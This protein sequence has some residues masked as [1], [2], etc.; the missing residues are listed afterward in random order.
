MRNR[1]HLPQ[2]FALLPTFRRRGVVRELIL[3]VLVGLT[4]IPCRIL[5]CNCESITVTVTIENKQATGHFDPGA[6][7]LVEDSSSTSES[8]SSASYS[9]SRGTSYTLKLNATAGEPP[10]G[11]SSTAT[12]SSC[13]NVLLFRK[14]QSE[15]YWQIG[16][17][18]LFAWDTPERTAGDCGFAFETEARSRT[19]YSSYFVK[20]EDTTG[21]LENDPVEETDLN[22]NGTIE[23]NEKSFDE[24][25]SVLFSSMGSQ[26]EA[27]MSTGDVS[28]GGGVTT[29]RFMATKLQEVKGTDEAG[30]WLEDDQKIV[31]MKTFAGW[32]T[33]DFYG[34]DLVKLLVGGEVVLSREISHGTV[35]QPFTEEELAPYLGTVLSAVNHSDEMLLMA[36]VSDTDDS[37][38]SGNGTSSGSSDDSGGGGFSQNG[39][40][41]EVPFNLDLGMGRN[42]QGYA[43]GT[44]KFSTSLDDPNVLSQSNV[45]LVQPF[46]TVFTEVQNPAVGVALRI[47]DSSTGVRVDEERATDGTALTFKVYTGDDNLVGTHVLTVIPEEAGVN[48]PGLRYTRTY[49]GVTQ[50]WEYYGKSTTGGRTWKEVSPDGSIKEGTDA[51]ISDSIRVSQRIE[52]LPGSTPGS[53]VVVRDD[54]TTYQTF[55]WGEEVVSRSQNLGGGLALATQYAYGTETGTPSYGKLVSQIN[56]DGSW[57]KSEYTASGTLLRVL[58]PW[59]DGPASPAAATLA[60]CRATTYTNMG[61][62][63]ES[64]E[65]E[66][67]QGKVTSRRYQLD[68]RAVQ[69]PLTLATEYAWQMGE[70]KA[71]LSA[72]VPD[73]VGDQATGAQNYRIQMVGAG[74]LLSEGGNLISQSLSSLNATD[75]V[76]ASG[77]NDWRLRS[78]SAPTA[79]SIQQQIELPAQPAQATVFCGSVD[80][81]TTNSQSIYLSV[82]GHEAF[83]SVSALDGAL[84]GQEVADQLSQSLSSQLNPDGNPPVAVVQIVNEGTGVLIQTPGTGAGQSINVSIGE[85][86]PVFTCDHDGETVHGSDISHPWNVVATGNWTK[87]GGGSTPA[88]AIANLISSDAGSVYDVTMT[89]RYTADYNL[90][91]SSMNLRK[92]APGV[93]RDKPVH[94][95]VSSS[96]AATAYSYEA[97]SFD[98]ITGSFNWNGGGNAVKTTTKRYAV[99]PDTFVLTGADPLSQVSME[100]Y[101]GLTRT[102]Q[103]WKGTDKVTETSH[104]YNPSTRD[105][106]F[107][108]ENGVTVFSA[109]RDTTN[110]TLTQTGADG[111]AVRTTYTS[112]GALLNTR[113][114]GRA[115]APDVISASSENGLESSSTTTAGGLTRKA[116]SVRDIAGRTVSSTDEN[117]L[118]T[119]YAYELGG[120]RV[121]ET[122]PNGGTRI[123]ENYLDGQL[124]SVTGTAVVPEYHT[125]LVDDDGNL[126][127]TVY[128]NDDGTGATRSPRWRSSTTNGLGWL[129]R[130]EAPAPGGAGVL[131]TVHHYNTKG[132]RVRTERPGQK[133]YLVT[134][135]DFGRVASQGVDIN[136]NGVLDLALSEPVTTTETTYESIDGHWWEKTTTVETASEDRSAPVRATISLRL[137]GGAL[138]EATVTATSDGLW[139]TTSTVRNPATKTV[140]TTTTTNRSALAAVQKV[141]NGLV[142]SDSSLT[143]TGSTT[144]EYDPLERI[145]TVTDPAGIT[146]RS[147]YDDLT[148][149][150]ARSRL[151]LEEVR[152]VGGTSFTT[153]R[154]YSYYPAGS[155][156]AGNVMT[157]TYANSTNTS[158]EYDLQGHQV[159]VSGSSSYPVR[160]QYD[161]Y[162]DLW[163]MHTYRT[164][165]PTSSSTGDVTTWHRDDATGALTSKEDASHRSASYT[166]EPATGRLH[167][168]TWARSPG[169]VSLT[170]TYIY[171]DAGRLWKVDYSD[172][173]PDVTYTY[174]ADGQLKTTG[175]AAGLHTY[176]YGGPNGTLSGETITGGLLDGASWASTFDMQKRRDSFTWAWGT[177]SRTT[178]YGYDSAGRLETVTAFGKTATYA[179][180]AGTGRLDTLSYTG[181]VGDWEYDEAGRLDKVVWSAGANVVSKH[182]YGYDAMHRR[183]TAIREN[184]EAWGYAY[185]DRGEVTGGAKKTSSAANAP[186]KQGLQFGYSYDLIGNRVASAEHTPGATAPD[187]LET[188]TGT[189]NE[190]NQITSRQHPASRWVLGHVH[191]A[192]TLNV[193]GGGTATREGDEFQ[194]P[195]NTTTAGAAE[196][197]GLE[198]TASRT[199]VGV[200]GGTVTTTRSGKLWFAASPESLQYD[201]D[202]N[203]T[204]DG[205]WSY[206][207]DAENRLKAMETLPS[208]ISAGVPPQ[209]LEFAYDAQGRRVRK[210]V[211]SF[212]S[213]TQTMEVTSDMRFLY[214]SWNLMAEF[215][216]NLQSQMPNLGFAFAWGRDL[217]G[218][219]QGAGGV[220]GL[221]LTELS[222][223]TTVN[224]P[225]GSLLRWQRQHHRLRQSRQQRGHLEARL[226][227]LRPPGVD[228]TRQWEW[229]EEQMPFRFQ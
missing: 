192:A 127:H 124:K 53:L 206:Q 21:V 118:T 157:V 170:T 89:E 84:S 147:V 22:D 73:L 200:G 63:A 13:S 74:M 201:F 191:P 113:K 129:I 139:T 160:Y 173:T 172:D 146:R 122:L 80:V 117:G 205:R 125:Y 12:V 56:P 197:R 166:Y 177:Q 19:Q 131:A 224:E 103:T 107:S 85:E 214:D 60:G 1:V 20:P 221:V 5:A 6:M 142:V 67:V 130:E 216:M 2:S 28:V 195:V 65:F 175:D 14:H 134:Y 96:G 46:S 77:T 62:G 98:S 33:V 102:E 83:F 198:V 61:S 25:K 24:R 178:S 42:S 186:V 219:M 121:I 64:W 225:P 52:R 148:D 181:L 208:A 190:L 10:C 168:R 43:D 133:D 132:Q 229:H 207:W 204:S 110:N 193:T 8:G 66:S 45:K 222:S 209:R 78:K 226:R 93:Q 151:K 30:P 141:V 105:R 4:A 111:T 112:A 88:P 59:L 38:D 26:P 162:G 92:N 215:A 3:A 50:V 163:K 101:Q 228:R 149:G 76:Y 87:I 179:Y 34:T 49:N 184:G 183:K 29:F 128:L 161:G 104:S 182:D 54:S 144:Y 210:V 176:I 138:N 143:A 187:G 44:V 218:T 154:S 194:I 16:S 212:N 223:S 70:W 164:G 48:D 137:I 199:G 95:T 165:T 17:T 37:N 40:D 9:I 152:P 150:T 156:G 136:G 220:G 180:E 71:S 23:A 116:T 145:A 86:S 169:G 55:P 91:D 94:F 68:W 36:W 185:N 79:F 159:F 32:G 7:S 57:T 213:T 188:V 51:K 97:G 115:G 140:T 41:S 109:L 31:G 171:D 27:W 196:W 123:T 158:Y 47:I 120:R 90:W 174:Y 82:N 189:P 75:V 108:K 211:K 155:A 69:N 202:G 167:T 11:G 35:E 81:A 135:D 15:S 227:S 106:I 99:D 126:T 203:L 153:E 100:D 72:P 58:R 114:I 217:S 119:T 39:D 18:G